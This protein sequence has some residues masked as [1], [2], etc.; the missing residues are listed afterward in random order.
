MDMAQDRALEP[1]AAQRG[2]QAST[3]TVP[4]RGMEFVLNSCKRAQKP[5]KV[6]P[7]AG[8][9]VSYNPKP[10]S[11]PLLRS[12]SWRG[13]RLPWGAHHH[14]SR[15]PG[16][17]RAWPKLQDFESLPRTPPSPA[18]LGCLCLPPEDGFDLPTAM[19]TAKRNDP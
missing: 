10:S 15:S 2:D 16:G 1:Q 8:V 13:Q 18:Q 14:R 7:S 3:Q 6:L 19:S 11:W 5:W 12:V 4:C 9:F 17:L